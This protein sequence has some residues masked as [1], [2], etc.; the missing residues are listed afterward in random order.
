MGRLCPRAGALT[1]PKAVRKP[2]SITSSNGNGGGAAAPRDPELDRAR[3]RA[4]HAALT[5][6]DIA[7]AGKLAEDALNDGIDNPMVL[8]LVAG[9]REEEGRLEEALALL[10]RALAAAPEAIGVMNAIGLVL[11][12]L[13]RFEEAVTAYGEALA[14]E[15]RFAPALAN[16]ATA[17][18]G[19][20]KLNAARADYEAAAGTGPGNVLAA[21]GLAALALRRGDP[22]EARRQAEAVLAR[23]PGFPGAVMTLAGADLAAGRAGGGGGG[24]GPARR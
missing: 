8:K 22:A 24:A 2:P 17:L 3:L 14:R 9:R 10:Q 7:T 12:R 6:G 4:V 21:N 15:P 13:G 20:A 19:Q 11:N 16:R 23:E 5:G 18:M 1:R